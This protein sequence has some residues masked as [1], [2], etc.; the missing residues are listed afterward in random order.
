MDSRQLYAEYQALAGR[1]DPAALQR[2][3]QL[4]PLI[5]Q[6]RKAERGG[7]PQQPMQP[8]PAQPPGRRL[9]SGMPYDPAI[10]QRLDE[11]YNQAGTMGDTSLMPGGVPR[12][13]AGQPIP[14]TPIGIPRPI[15]GQNPITTPMPQNGTWGQPFPRRR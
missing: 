13:I 1:R 11:R 9:D 14:S 2:R 15:A 8:V 6:A 5:A 3:S 7:M 12:P 10:S 4:V